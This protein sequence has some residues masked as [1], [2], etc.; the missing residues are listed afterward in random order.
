VINTAKEA[1]YEAGK[2]LKNNF[3]KLPEEAIRR[4]SVNDFLSFVDEES[5]KK[6]LKIIQGAYPGHSF[7]A[8]ESGSG[9]AKDSPL[10]IIDPL[11]G[12]TNYIHRIPV[13][14][15]SIGLQQE[16]ELVLGIVY[17]PVTDEMFWAEKGRGA[18]L[19]DQPIQVSETKEM[20][21]SLLATGF[22]FKTKQVLP[23]Y[24]TAFESI[25]RD[26][27]GIRRMGAAAIDLAFVAA[28]RLDGFWEIGLSPWDVAAG[29]LIIKEAGGA[30]TDFWNNE[31][32]LHNN[33]IVSSNGK[34]HNSLLQ[35]LQ[36]V[37]PFYKDVY[38]NKGKE[39]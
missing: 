32:Y 16:N 19:N 22:P 29:A 34:I 38:K 18:F 1:A 26:C 28:G 6:I 12:T 27:R 11:D 39:S 14:A 31:Y 17:N 37:F 3:G 36:N 8:E 35:N 30:V 23:E 2:I 7:L 24:L 5:E 21:N 9:G 4:K 15:V 10:W 13:F 20:Q 33:Y 25:F